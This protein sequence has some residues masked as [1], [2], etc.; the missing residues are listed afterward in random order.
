MLGYDLNHVGKRGP[1]QQLILKN[2]FVINTL[3]SLTP[4][5]SGWNFR[6][7]ILRIDSMMTSSNENI[8]RVTGPLCGEFTG[9]GE[10]PTQ[11]PVTRSFDVFFDLRLN[12]RLSK[13]TWGWWFETLSWSLW[14]QCNGFH[15]LLWNCQQVKAK[16]VT[17]DKSTL[18]HV[19]A[20]CRQ[21]TSH[22]LSQCWPRSM[23]PYGVTR[24]QWVL[25]PRA[26]CILITQFIL[27]HYN[28]IFAINWKIHC[29]HDIVLQLRGRS[30]GYSASR[31]LSLF[32]MVLRN[33]IVWIT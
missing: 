23:S 30:N 2:P 32:P 9:P 11:R 24:L 12:K 16:G 33:F 1:W 10:F 4:G 3:Y 18:V 19:M 25:R 6:C 15:I 13:Q 28:I 26:P 31:S 14:R 21:A 5:R 29:P 27:S 17:D 20:W 8:F 22:Y 7:V